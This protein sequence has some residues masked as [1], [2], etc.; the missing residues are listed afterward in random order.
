VDWFKGK[1][2]GS[3]GKNVVQGIANGITAGAS[4]IA[5][6]A[7]AAARAAWE[8]AKGFF[9]IGSPSKLFQVVGHDVGEGLALGILESIGTVEGAVTQMLS[10]AAGLG[11]I[12]ST[13]GGFY[14]EGVLDPLSDNLDETDGQIEETEGN[15]EK[16]KEAFKEISRELYAPAP[17]GLTPQEETERLVRLGREYSRVS[18]E[19]STQQGRRN[20]LLGRRNQLASDFAQLSERI[21]RLEESR[22]RL[23]FLQEQVKL[24][25][26]IT[27]H[28]LDVEEVLGGMQLGLEAS[29]EELIDATTRAMQGIVQAAND[30]LGLRSPSRVFQEKGQQ[31]SQGLMLGLFEGLDTAAIQQQMRTLVPEISP[32]PAVTSYNVTKH[33]APNYNLTTQSMVRPGGLRMEFEAMEAAGAIAA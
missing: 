8:A 22:S 11:Q 20:E 5:N 15:I 27:E 10:A 28:G 21:N 24:L 25:D 9:G 2:W 18:R 26:L 3:V 30:E 17:T 14:E 7:K 4:L 31:I 19:L 32:I 1:D 13:F 23:R 12:G 16:L 33:L 6:A 29:T